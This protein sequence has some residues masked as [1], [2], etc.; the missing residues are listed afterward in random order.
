MIPAPR[1]ATVSLLARRMAPEGRKQIEGYC[2]DA[3]GLIQSDLPHL[4]QYADI[5]Q[6]AGNVIA[7]EILGGC[8]QH[9]STIAF[10]GSNESVKAALEA[11]SAAK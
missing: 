7:V 4:F 10:F 1:P 8:P 5:G 9:I 11:V 2:F 3:V 6:K